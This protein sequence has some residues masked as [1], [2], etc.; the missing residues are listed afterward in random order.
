MRIGIDIDGVLTDISGAMLDNASKFFY[1]NNIKYKLDSSEYD[2]GKMFGVD[3]E[4]VIKFWNACLVDYVKNDPVRKY[5]K[6]VIE[7]LKEKNEIYL[8]TARDEYGMPEDYYGKM[9]ELTKQWL[10]K[11]NIVYDKLIFTNE[12]LEACIENKIDIMIDDSPSKIYEVAKEIKTFCYDVQ[13]N[14]DVKGENITRV[15]SWYDILSKI[16]ELY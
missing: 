6:E 12:K 11:N 7:K 10:L 8:I 16:E 15:Y 3:T 13:Y 2:D 5:A 9:E 4:S 14:R 1:E